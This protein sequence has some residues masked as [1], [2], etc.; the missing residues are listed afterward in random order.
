MFDTASAVATCGRELGHQYHARR[1]LYNARSSCFVDGLTAVS[2]A[3][4]IPV[5]CSAH[6]LLPSFAFDPITGGYI[7]VAANADFHV[8][9]LWSPNRP[10][11]PRQDLERQSEMLLCPAHIAATISVSESRHVF[12]TR[13]TA[14]A[15]GDLGNIAIASLRKGPNDDGHDRLMWAR[16]ASIYLTLVDREESAWQVSCNT[17]DGARDLAAIGSSTHAHVIT[18]DGDVKARCPTG[19]DVLAVDWLSQSVAILGSRNGVSL[20]DIRDSRRI[21]TRFKHSDAVYL[22]R[23]FG[24]KAQLMATGYETMSLYDVRMPSMTQSLL[25]LDNKGSRDLNRFDAWPAANLLARVNNGTLEF[26]SLS[27]GKLLGNK[28]SRAC[29][30]HKDVYGHLLNVRFQ[31]D[32]NGVMHLHGIGE[33]GIVRWTYG[34]H[35]D[36]ITEGWRSSNDR[37]LTGDRD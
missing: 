22:L 30:Y 6:N 19:K 12:F 24:N 7:Y 10:V 37:S 15:H 32:R 26:R 13:T 29:G 2:G 3:S 33:D 23:D 9:R 18:T 17:N 35:G 4:P 36:D 16:D 34:G 21:V 25:S 20:W 8:V 1:G 5:G 11:A 28:Q 27:D 31:E 14:G